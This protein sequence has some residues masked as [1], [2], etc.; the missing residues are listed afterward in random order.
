MQPD[1]PEQPERPT[2]DQIWQW[3][4]SLPIDQR[5]YPTLEAFQEAVLEFVRK[6]RQEQPPKEG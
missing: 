1:Q 5:N 3:I 2:D 4:Q 6:L